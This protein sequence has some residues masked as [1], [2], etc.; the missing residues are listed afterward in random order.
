MDKIQ[1][2]QNNTVNIIILGFFRNAADYLSSLWM[3]FNR[4]ENKRTVKPLNDFMAGR[5]YLR[6]IGKLMTLAETN[7]D[8]TFHLYPYRP[9]NQGTDSVTQAL[10]TIG[11]DI[12]TTMQVKNFN[13]SMTR[14]EADIRQLALTKNWNFGI[15]VTTDDIKKIAANIKTG[16]RRPV[17]E[18][19]S[20]EVI[21]QTCLDHAP[22]LDYLMKINPFN[23]NVYFKNVRPSCFGKQ[24]DAYQPISSDEYNTIKEMLQETVT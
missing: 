24:R 11:V 6:G 2:L 14:I 22:F 7:P 10:Q 3:E 1:Y 8:Y 19:L 20:D 15:N 17:I 18:T 4:F 13:E 5:D 12:E 21:E 16:D 9:K 23:T